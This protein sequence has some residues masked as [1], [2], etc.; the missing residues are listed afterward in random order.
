MFRSAKLL[1]ALAIL[2]GIA[3][4]SVPCIATTWDLANDFSSTANPNGPWSFGI[5]NSPG[6][7]LGSW[8]LDPTLGLLNF[9]ASTIAFWDYNETG[10]PHNAGGVGKNFGAG[11]AFDYG[12]GKFY[13]E[14]G[15]VVVFGM[16]EQFGGKVLCQSKIRWTAPD[17]YPALRVHG[18]FTSQDITGGNPGASNLDVSV[19][20]R[21]GAAAYGHLNGFYGTTANGYADRVGATPYMTFDTVLYNVSA[22]DVIGFRVTGVDNATWYM[23]HAGLAATID[24]VIP[25]TGTVSG[26]VLASGGA[27]LDGATVNAVG[28]TAKAITAG[29]GYYT[30]TLAPGTYTIRAHKLGWERVAASSSVT[31]VGGDTPTAATVTL[32]QNYWYTASDEDFGTTNPNGPWTFGYKYSTDDTGFVKVSDYWEPLLDYNNGPGD[33]PLMNWTEAQ[34]HLNANSGWHIYHNVTPY[35]EKPY[36]ACYY[37]VA[38]EPEASGVAGAPNGN[39]TGFQ[40]KSPVTGSLQVSAKFS[41]Q[42][43]GASQVYVVRGTTGRANVLLATAT[44]NGFAGSSMNGYTDSSGAPVFSWSGTL[45]NVTTADSVCFVK[46]GGGLV[47]VDAQMS[48][49]LV[50][51]GTVSGVV[52]ANLGTSH[53]PVAGALVANAAGAE[54]TTTDSAGHYTLT[55]LPGT[56]SLMAS[57]PAYESLTVNNVSVTSGNTTTQNFDLPTSFIKGKVMTNMS[58]NAPIV[59]ASVVTSDGLASGVTDSAGNYSLQVSQGTYTVQVY[60]YGYLRSQASVPVGVGATATHDFYLAIGWDFA[61][62][63]NAANY[64]LATSGPWSYMYDSGTNVIMMNNIG[65]MGSGGVVGVNDMQWWGSVGGYPRLLKNL[66][67]TPVMWSNNGS[68]YYREPGKVIGDTSGVPGQRTIARFTAPTGGRFTVSARWAGVNHT[69]AETSDVAVLYNDTYLFGNPSSAP[70]QLN[71]FAGT[72]AN[73]YADSFGAAPVITWSQ[74]LD[75]GVGETVDCAIMAPDGWAWAQIDMTVAPAAGVG[76]ISG[77]V[78]AGNLPGNPPVPNATVNA[79]P[80]GYTAITDATGAYYLAV[81]EGDYNVTAGATGYNTP[82]Y[83]VTVTSGGQTT[84]N[85]SLTHAGTWD[86]LA[87]Y[88]NLANPNGQ[89]AVGT[90]TSNVLTPYHVALPFT[91]DVYVAPGVPVWRNNYSDGQTNLH[92]GWF[93]KNT[94][95]AVSWDSGYVDGNTTTFGGEGVGFSNGTTLI[96]AVRWTSPDTRIIKIHFDVTDQMTYNTGQNSLPV[97][98]KRNG[99][100]MVTKTVSGFIGRA[101]NHYTDSIGP[102]PRAIFET[103]LL[104]NAGDTLDLA[105]CQSNGATW[106]SGIQRSSIG[107]SMTV[108]P[109]SGQACASIGALKSANVGDNVFLTTPTTLACGSD[110]F[111]D[112]SFYIENDDRSQGM[113]CVGA[114]DIP[115]YAQGA[116]ITFSGTIALDP[117]GSGQKVVMVQSINGSDTGVAPLPLG[118]GSKSWSAT[119]T[120]KPLNMLVTVWGVVT[121]QVLSSPADPDHWAWQYWVINDGGQAI[122]IPMNVQSGLMPSTSGILGGVREGDYISITGIATLDSSGNVVVTPWIESNFSSYAGL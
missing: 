31:V 54:S 34:G 48:L 14:S 107:V 51:P 83:N 21:G 67:T 106:G 78:T 114:A 47:N 32:R 74:D 96:P 20:Y 108:S 6:Y 65:A 103:S 25:T 29:G 10:G 69:Y 101:V 91:S 66:L 63:F 18:M 93:G 43:W 7:G 41:L 121:Q 59:G 3:L 95:A 73:S 92:Y 42:G 8:L 1:I 38:I 82:G 104:V 68:D 27:G 112:Y 122:K 44:V 37:G 39:P 120:M 84:Q 115:T 80:G 45:T 16:N 36:Y 28:T 50:P 4:A 100:I 94:G 33:F 97:S 2:A 116:K 87:D 24:T 56:Y 72:A 77:Y 62:D 119:T 98:L 23:G 52:T 105:L 5:E 64:P 40:W 13:A 79:T 70:Q 60:K 102:S 30:L 61:A 113:K 90:L 12:S 99:N 35:P 85:Y 53:P 81:P 117:N 88:T 58:G 110:R 75:L 11:A 118:T 26:R 46:S 86:L 89:W 55:L 49:V 17:S 57:K 9:G 71:G 76:Y 22:G 109:G 15:Q 111:Q 19:D